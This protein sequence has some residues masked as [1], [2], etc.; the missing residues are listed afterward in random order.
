MDTLCVFD[1]DDTLFR[2]PEQ[3][4]NFKGNWKIS[5]ESLS[6]PHVP[7]IPSD[8][9]WN[10]NIVNR[11]KECIENK[12]NY[13]VMLTGRID[14]FFED[15]I[16]QLLSQKQL[17]FKEVHL[18][19]FGEDTVEFKIQKINNILRRYPSIK[20]IKFWDDKK[21]YLQKYLDEFKQNYKVYSNIVGNIIIKL[22]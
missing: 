12:N 10:L 16:K 2:S 18:N 15:R 22:K 20:N 4:K 14:R 6:E 3:P 8:I 5:K 7:E 17:N 1:F 11:A 9:F 13:C 21:E 19:E